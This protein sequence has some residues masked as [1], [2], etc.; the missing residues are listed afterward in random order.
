MPDPTLAAIQHRF[1]DLVT[2]FAGDA[3][4]LLASG[5][6]SV[7]ARMY[8]ARLFDVLADDYPKLRAALDDDRFGEL[9]RR[10]L[11]VHPPRSF[12]LR[13]LGLDLPAFLATG[14]VDAPPW[15]ADLARLERARIEVFDGPDAAHL[16][17]DTVASGAPEDLPS[18][19]LRWMPA[20]TVVTIAW[21]VDELWSAIED[22][23]AVTEPAPAARTVLVWR[24][25]VAV[26][27]RTLDDDEAALADAIAAGVGFAEVCEAL[28]AGGHDEPAARAAELLLR[29]LE[30][31]ALRD[32]VGCILP[33]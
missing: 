3:T 14:A 15:A 25:A 10:Y 26:L 8:A 28:A 21:A 33:A 24:K 12:T 11:R 19:R 22:G 9:V 13:D 17:R 2:A 29:W 4:G 31:E 7:Y 30:A 18:L 23:L 1:Y 20:S 32:G 5:D 16:T 27:H 6:L